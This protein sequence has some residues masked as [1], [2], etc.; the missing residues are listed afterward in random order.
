MT[1]LPGI[2][3]LA[4]RAA[5]AIALYAFLGWA[6]LT[7]WRDLRREAQTPD[8]QEPPEIRLRIANGEA[9][10]TQRLR[11]EAIT[12]GRD[13]NCECV[14]PSE[15][16]SARHAQ[17]SFHHGQWWLDDLN[18]TNGT[19]LNGERVVTGVVTAPGDE[20]RCGDV[21][22]HILEENAIQ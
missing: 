9:E 7:L 13:F 11:G 19:F 12:L 6:L 8:G 22:L 15:T 5:L 14:L 17:L 2:L 16:V 4:V 1:E 21:V 10:S 18:S 20:I 3:L